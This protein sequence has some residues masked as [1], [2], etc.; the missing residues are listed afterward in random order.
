MAGNSATEPYIVAHNVLLS[1]AS[2]A[3]IYRKKYKNIQGGSLG[4]AFD[5]FGLSLPQTFKKTLKRHRE[6][7][8][9]IRISTIENQSLK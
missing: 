9:E 1:H 8:I 7:K 5:V 2:V 4:I 3:D 6:L